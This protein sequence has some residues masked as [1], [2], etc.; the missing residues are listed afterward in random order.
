MTHSFEINKA[1]HQSASRT[2][3][4]FPNAGAQLPD[5]HTHRWTQCPHCH[6]PLPSAQ[7]PAKKV[8]F[9]EGKAYPINEAPKTY[10]RRDGTIMHLRMSDG[11]YVVIG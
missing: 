6:Q 11:C 1:A 8:V 7:K 9:C 3:L 10:T 5:V 2:A 4:E